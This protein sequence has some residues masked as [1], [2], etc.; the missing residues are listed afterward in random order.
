MILTL[1]QP[2]H[3]WGTEMAGAPYA[4]EPAMTWRTLTGDHTSTPSQGLRVV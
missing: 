4:G 3:A 1:R 2:D